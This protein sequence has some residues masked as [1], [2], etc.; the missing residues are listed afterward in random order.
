[1]NMVNQRIC[2]ENIGLSGDGEQLVLLEV[3]NMTE[4]KYKWCQEAFYYTAYTRRVA[5][6]EHGHNQTS[7]KQDRYSTGAI[8]MELLGGSDLVL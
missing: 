6:N 7:F 5:S 8:I 2:P 4:P 3:S 1:M